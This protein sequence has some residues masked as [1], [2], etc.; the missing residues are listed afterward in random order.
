MTQTVFAVNTW[1][2]VAFVLYL[3]AMVAIG[4]L[5]TRFSSSGLAEFFLGGRQMKSFVVALAAVTS[6]RSAWLLI[7]VA[8]MAFTRGASAIWTVV[9]YILMELFLFLGPGKRLRRFTGQ[10]DDLTIPDFL[11]SRMADK[12]HLIRVATVLPILIFMVSYV[13]AQFTAG[14]KTL[15][16]S[17]GSSQTVGLLITAGIVVFYTMMGGFLAICLTDVVQACLMIFALVILPIIAIIHLGGLT[18]LFRSLEALNPQFIDPFALSVGTFISFLGIG[19]GSPGNPHILNKHM[20]IDDPEKLPRTGIIAT[21]WNVIMAWGS[22]Y[23]G[24]AGRVIFKDIKALPNQDPENIYPLLASQHLHP[25]I[26][27]LTIAAI[28]AAIMSTA[29]S[30][31][32]VAS[33]AIVRDLYQKIFAIK[34]PLDQKKLVFWGRVATFLLAI[35]ALIMGFMAK[36]LVFYLV[37]FAWGGLGAALGPSILLSLY[38]PRLTKWG[39]ISG[40]IVGTAV[41]IIWYSQA[42]L[43]ALVSEWVPATGLSL[44][45]VII[46]SLMTKPP[47]QAEALLKIMSEKTEISRNQ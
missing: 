16:A 23:I 39:V 42:Q 7:A 29:D 9:G 30:Q 31:L 32:L 25:F 44:I 1:T 24:L 11:A 18:V 43:K 45:T 17:F 27:G 13:S 46:V 20:S 38:W 34:K 19:F 41:E 12:T 3:V 14:A 26:Y 40:I 21:C 8:G 28:F 2:V 22:V 35:V 5:T 47:E 6:G 10:M 36:K 15:A 33:S 4:L 37:L